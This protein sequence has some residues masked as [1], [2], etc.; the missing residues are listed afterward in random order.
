MKPKGM[1]VDEYSKIHGVVNGF[2]DVGSITRLPVIPVTLH[3]IITQTVRELNKIYIP[4]V[5][6]WVVQKRPKIW[7][8]IK[9]IENGIQMAVICEDEEKLR[10]LLKEYYDVWIRMCVEFEASGKKYVPF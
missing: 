5:V 4:Y 1:T 10:E 8:E 6:G 9:E 7:G 3:D 2:W